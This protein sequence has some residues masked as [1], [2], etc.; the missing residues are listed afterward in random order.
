MKTNNPSDKTRNQNL[1]QD[2]NEST[3]ESRNLNDPKNPDKNRTQHSSQGSTAE[4]AGDYRSN[5]G[6]GTASE[7]G[8][9]Q[10]EKSW[11]DT[12]GSQGGY[13]R[14]EGIAAIIPTSLHQVQDRI[15]AA[16]K[17]VQGI[18][19]AMQAIRKIHL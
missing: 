18:P 11:Q 4:H 7:A 1:E 10:S 19:A 12:G 6:T 17:P 15:G 5:K 2:V 3:G 8:S 14:K 9:S 16:N 13:Q